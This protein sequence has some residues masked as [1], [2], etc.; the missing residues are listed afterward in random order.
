MNRFK[1]LSRKWKILS[2]ILLIGF[3]ISWVLV[4]FIF[5]RRSVA[6][7][8]I[9]NFKNKG[10]IPQYAN[11]SNPINGSLYTQDESEAW[12]NKLPLAIVIENHTDARPQ[13]GLNR[14]DVVYETLAE[15]GITRLL[16]IFLAEDSRVG[17]VRSNRP[18]FLDWV[19]EYGAGYSH[20]GG[21]PE[22]QHLVKA[23]KIRDLDQF[24]IGFPTYERVSN[25][26]A[27]HNVYTTTTR[28]RNTA[29]SK[30]YKVPANINSWLFADMEPVESGRGN[31][32]VLNIGFLGTFG[33]DVKW[34]YDRKS[35][36]YARFNAGSK[37]ID[38]EDGRQIS[39]KTI[40][41]QYT[42]ISPDPSGHGRVKIQ[43][44]GTG[45]V[46]VF[47]DGMVMIGTWRKK[48][49]EDRTRFFDSGGKEITLNRGKIWIEVVPSRST[50]SFSK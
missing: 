46:Q 5:G 11:V 26:F 15:G 20:V 22:A 50:V 23:Y 31:K 38:A 24:F 3:I 35:N 7:L 10:I 25:R 17:P 1:N 12:K 9:G 14:A 41:V 8:P 27:P 47:K 49:R 39:A 30:G 33:Y 16:A 48:S 37:H 13:S 4:G 44:I 34:I 32:F 29:S 45:K 6:T 28:L 36:S 2:L 42:N 21:S 19:S 40:V 43:T 18:Y